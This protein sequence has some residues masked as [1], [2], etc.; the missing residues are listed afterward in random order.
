MNGLYQPP[1]V[2]LGPMHPLDNEMQQDPEPHVRDQSAHAEELMETARKLKIEAATA[3]AHVRDAEEALK[4]AM[5]AAE[6]AANAANEAKA[7]AEAAVYGLNSS[8]TLPP[9][10]RF[11][12]FEELL[13]SA[14]QHAA[15]QGYALSAG[16]RRKRKDGVRQ[17]IMVQCAR[18]GVY[19]DR[20]KPGERKR[21]ANT[22][23]TECEFSFN[24]C[25]MKEDEGGGWELRYREGE[26]RGKH[27]HGPT[28]EKGMTGKWGNRRKIRENEK[29]RIPGEGKFQVNVA[30]GGSEDGHGTS[31]SDGN[32]Q[33][34][35]G[36]PIQAN[37]GQPI[38]PPPS[39]SQM[40]QRSNIQPDLGQSS[41]IHPHLAQQSNSIQPNLGQSSNMQPNLGQT[42]SIANTMSEVS[43]LL[44][45]FGG[46]NG[47]SQARSTY[48]APA[49][50]NMG[51]S[52]NVQS[53]LGHG[54]RSQANMGQAGNVMGGNMD[55]MERPREREIWGMGMYQ[56]PNYQ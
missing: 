11:A 21:K 30:E 6:V 40:P 48:A 39:M 18:G 20:T 32:I 45:G 46:H 14:Q 35:L 34:N 52:S 5:A 28:W 38:N 49:Q 37:M 27:N 1:Q 4:A 8:M 56:T 2:P 25:Q 7:C 16:R 36:Q 26:G 29:R 55:G 41:N 23:K 22:R 33:P 17:L 47:R 13:E 24:A 50:A 31:A 9:Q 44:A 10:G 51:Q 53:N 3:Q 15:A 12:T 54:N 19:Q 43:S 42:G